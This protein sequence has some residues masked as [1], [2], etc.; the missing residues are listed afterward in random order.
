[1]NPNIRDTQGRTPLYYAVEGGHRDC[2]KEL[3]SCKANPELSVDEKDQKAVHLAAENNNKTILKI[4]LDFGALSDERNKIGN[5]PIDIAL[6]K[7]YPNILKLLLEH[8][9]KLE[10]NNYQLNTPMHTIAVCN[11]YK[12]ADYLLRES[13]INLAFEQLNRRNVDKE[14]PIDI[15]KRIGHD[16]VLLTYIETVH[17]DYFADNPIL[18]HEFLEANQYSIL[19]KIFDRM[20]TEKRY[21]RRT[22]MHCT[23]EM[24]DTNEKG[25]SPFS[26][27]FSHLLPSLLHKLLDC[28]DKELRE[29]PIVKK[30]VEKK[31]NFYRLWYTLTFLL[32]LIFMIVLSG[33]LFLASYDCDS[34]LRIE[35]VTP[36]SSLRIFL[37]ILVWAFAIVLTFSELVEFAYG[38][39]KIF[40]AQRFERMN[41][42]THFF[43]QDSNE[44]TEISLLK[45]RKNYF[46]QLLD[47]GKKISYIIPLV[48]RLFCHFPNALLHYLY[49]SPLDVLGIGSLFGY[50]FIRLDNPSASWIFASLAYIAFITSLLKYTRIIP[51]LGA[52][53]DTVKAV[54]SKDIP[55]FLVLYT[56]M[57]VAFVGGLHLAS[58]FAITSPSQSIKLTPQGL[59][60]T[61]CSNDTSGMFYF[62]EDLTERYTILKPLVTGIILLLDGGPGNREDDL[63][64]INPYFTLVYLF[65]SFM[66]IVVLSNIL[67]AQLSETYATL[68]AQGTFYYR[69]GLV[70]TM[71]LESS[72]AFFLGKYFRQ[73]SSIRTFKLPIEE[74]KTLLSETPDQ[75]VNSQLGTLE[76]R[77][78]KS[79]VIL[80]EGN[81]K[82]LAVMEH[83]VILG[84]KLDDVQNKCEHIKVHFEPSASFDTQDPKQATPKEMFAKVKIERRIGMLESSVEEI[85][86]Q[87][88][89]MDNKL[90]QILEML[91]K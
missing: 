47:G 60:D 65:F 21:K 23:A 61:S 5:T 90:N 73:L 34:D 78:N 71:E 63:F 4:L 20:C 89:T 3:L 6:E 74:W 19:K 68:S 70:V 11:S 28:G 81:D 87:N 88:S 50:F 41:S 40:K 59:P 86:V 30:T 79:M 29:H 44:D 1:M 39:S 37:E 9:V 10:R 72:L 13:K 58:R 85:R 38:W 66:I 27:N 8:G 42:V 69:M 80:S 15:A 43:T 48:D 31:L 53:I 32:Y 46:L 91:K 82:N 57:L 54:F 36:N 14:T 64:D 33:A 51:S 67:I 35:D 75:N 26:K 77:I 22:K 25:Q 24:L 16:S 52:Y 45:D 7:D 18:Y 83:L 55:R 84:E 56:V 2:V 76:D 17:R 12:C 62:N 49:D